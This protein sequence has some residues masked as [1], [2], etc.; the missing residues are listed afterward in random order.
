MGRLPEKTREYLSPPLSF[1][2]RE[3]AEKREKAKQSFL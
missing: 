2:G 1:E 3:P